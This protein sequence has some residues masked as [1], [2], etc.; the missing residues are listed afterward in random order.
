MARNEDVKN[1]LHKHRAQVKPEVYGIDTQQRRV[2]GLRREEVAQ[3]AAVSV[4]WYTWLE[5]GRDIR[6]S[7]AAIQRIGKV[8]QLTPVEQNYFSAIVF[9][10]TLPSEQS[11]DIPNEVKVMV[12]ALHPYP[13]FVRRENMDI[14]YWNRAAQENIFDWTQVPLSDRNSLKLMFIDPAYKQRIGN[15]ESAALHTIAAFR[16]Y[17]AAGRNSADFD[18]IVSDLSARSADFV[19]LWQRHEVSRMGAGNKAILDLNSEMKHYTYTSLEVENTPGIF[20]IF[21]APVLDNASQTGCE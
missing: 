19:A 18:S 17:Q 6:I 9:G 5:Q 16:N 10:H 15:W 21:Y 8:L 20:V 7:P 3:L 12:D 14:L 13:A 11:P 2:P 4:S 1:F